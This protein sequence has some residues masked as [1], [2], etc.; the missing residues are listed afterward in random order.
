MMT[1]NIYVDFQTAR[2]W[3]NDRQLPAY[4]YYLKVDPAFE[5]EIVTRLYH[6]GGVASVQ[7]KSSMEADWQALFG[8]FYSFTGTV[9]LFAMV[10]VFALQF[11]SI[12]VNIL[13]RERELATM[14]SIGM[15]GRQVAMIITAESFF[16]FLLALGPGILAG[17]W[18]AD[19]MGNAFKTELFSFSMVV[20][21]RSYIISAVCIL[22]TIL[23][24]AIPALRRINRLNLAESTKILT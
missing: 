21:A 16:L 7:R 12:T 4:G 23:L 18:A 5:K 24:A 22:I 8:L 20:S 14:R 3:S 15:D 19:Q 1:S 10:M 11:N 17:S 2:D 13:E 9:L 6:L